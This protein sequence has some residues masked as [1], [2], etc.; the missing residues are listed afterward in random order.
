[1]CDQVRVQEYSNE[2]PKHWAAQTAT[3]LQY[4]D[5]AC[6]ATKCHFSNMTASDIIYHS[7]LVITGVSQEWLLR[8]PGN[9]EGWSLSG[10]LVHFLSSVYVTLSNYTSY[11]KCVHM[12]KLCLRQQNYECLATP[13]MWKF[14]DISQCLSPKLNFPFSC[15]PRNRNHRVQNSQCL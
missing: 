9:R 5:C 10:D 2:F 6:P 14:L 15:V 3:P 4:L 1:M 11:L 8:M 12:L 7:N 13:L